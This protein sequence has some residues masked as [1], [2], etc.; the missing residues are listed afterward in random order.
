MLQLVYLSMTEPRK[1]TALFHS[2]VQKNKSQFA[3][4]SANPQAAFV[5]TMYKSL[6]NNN[7]LAPI[8]VPNSAYYDKIDLDRSLAIY[9]E[10][11]GD[12][13]GMHFTFVGSFKEARLFL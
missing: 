1:D 2:Y 10:H 13:N 3:M 9:K 7:P 4:L 5:D 8:A 6:F 12:A 11:F